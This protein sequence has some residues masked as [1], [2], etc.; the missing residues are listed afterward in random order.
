MNSKS[1]NSV[2]H[3]IH[4]Q[5]LFC[6]L[7]RKKKQNRSKMSWLHRCLKCQSVITQPV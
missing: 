2:A 6:N 5:F 1:P 3:H 4:V 7:R